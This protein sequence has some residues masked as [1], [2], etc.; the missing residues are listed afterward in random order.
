MSK[1]WV[2]KSTLQLPDIGAEAELLYLLEIKP[3]TIFYTL[4]TTGMPCVVASVWRPT[5]RE[6]VGLPR[7]FIGAFSCWRTD[8]DGE[9]CG[10]AEML[11]TGY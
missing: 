1:C 3:S 8:G 4:L 5:G 2:P 9:V 6:A 10:R 7:G 11:S